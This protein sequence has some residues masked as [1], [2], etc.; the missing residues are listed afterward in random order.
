MD[1]H[2]GGQGPEVLH[3]PHALSRRGR[4]IAGLL[5][6]GLLYVLV[7]IFSHGPLTDLDVAVE[8]WDG[9]K[10]IPSLDRVAWVYDKVGQRSVLVPLLLV[11]AGT[12]GRRH[13]TW[14]PVVLAGVSFLILNVV[15]GAMKILIGRSET[16]TGDPSVLNGG[17][18]FPSGHSSNMVL[19]GGLIIYLLMRYTERPPVRR[20]VAVVSV[21][22]T[23]T[24]LTSVYIGSH[25][26]SD[27]IG[28]ALVGGLLLQAVIVFDRKTR[29]VRND[30]PAI[31]TPALRLGLFE[32]DADRVDAVAV[33]GGRLGSVVEDVPEVRPAPPAPDLRAPHPE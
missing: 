15:V 14:R 10:S 25:W 22:T 26:V 32:P 17:V 31:L 7:D 2:G 23:L 19:T 16:E 9:E 21:M 20:L 4:T 12:L 1:L 28:G 11:V 3:R 8:R 6:A 13:R 24:I 27:L 5:S 30:P 18:I 29:H 33:P